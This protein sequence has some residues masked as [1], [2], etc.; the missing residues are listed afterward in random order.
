[1]AVFRLFFFF[2]TSHK[3]SSRKKKSTGGPEAAFKLSVAIGQ[4]LLSEAEGGMSE[5][6]KDE[7][8]TLE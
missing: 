8:V 4:K 3:I 6:R 5:K 7:D 1:M 2:G